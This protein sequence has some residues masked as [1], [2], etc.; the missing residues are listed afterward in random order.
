MSHAA[1]YSSK[2]RDL[3]R[4]NYNFFFIILIINLSDATPP[5]CRVIGFPVKRPSPAPRQFKYG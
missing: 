4:E 1:F 3:G 5:D 2:G